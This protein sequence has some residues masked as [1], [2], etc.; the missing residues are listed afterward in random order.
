MLGSLKSL[1]FLNQHVSSPQHVSD[2]SSMLLEASELGWGEKEEAELGMATNEAQI[3]PFSSN[4]RKT[5][6]NKRSHEPTSKTNSSPP[7]DFFL[8]ITIRMH[9]YD[10]L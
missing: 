2:P 6:V 10:L 3:L 9:M 8:F 1:V 5:K 4:P 7:I